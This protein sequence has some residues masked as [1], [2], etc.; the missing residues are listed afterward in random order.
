[1]AVCVRREV[2]TIGRDVGEDGRVELEDE[3]SADV[4][5]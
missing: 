4:D 1:M 2:R 3:V 5:E